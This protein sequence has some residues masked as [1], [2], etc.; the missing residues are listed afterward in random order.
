MKAMNISLNNVLVFLLLGILH[1]T[2]YY[3]G[4]IVYVSNLGE[5]LAL[6]LFLDGI[7]LK[8][9]SIDKDYIVIFFLCILPVMIVS[10]IQIFYVRDF[11]VVKTLIHRCLFIIAAF[12]IVKKISFDC[13]TSYLRYWGGINVIVIAIVFAFG[14]IEILDSSI[15]TYGAVGMSYMGLSF[16]FQISVFD[17]MIFRCGGLFGHPNN[18]GLLSAIGFIGVINSNYSY[19]QK[20]FWL[21][22]FVISFLINESRGSVLIVGLYFL[23]YQLFKRKLTVKN[24]LIN[25]GSCMLIA[26][27][28]FSLAYLR[29][30][31]GTDYATGRAGLLAGISQ[32]F[33]TESELVQLFGVGFGNVG[34]YVV[35]KFA[36]DIPLDDS[37]L[38]T[39][40]ELGYIGELFFL[41]SLI[42]VIY[43]SY[44]RTSMEWN[45]WFSF[46]VA[47]GAHSL[48]ESDFV[49]G[50]Y[51]YLITFLFYMI[52]DK[53]SYK[54]KTKHN[55]I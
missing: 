35:S 41:I 16:P 34:K 46:L 45:V 32:K 18:F 36:A 9:W 25:A 20:L 13:F 37:Y 44:K 43:Y 7:F 53:S 47:F 49:G 12:V 1:I 15:H 55:A 50:K 23:S 3:H 10:F 54:D 30:D 39:L 24:M 8:K 21:M 33:D 4:N 38:Y 2:F 31:T 51:M 40:V 6:L 26:S 19:K 42:I 5:L 22:V 11:I 52:A 27:I 28:F 48:F 17:E 14:S 29:D